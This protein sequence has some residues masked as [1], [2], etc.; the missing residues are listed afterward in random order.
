M[1]RISV[2]ESRSRLRLV[3]EGKLAAPWTVELRRRW[4]SARAQVRGRALVID[5][6]NVTHI[7]REG[8]NVLLDLM[9]EGARFTCKGVFTRR[10]LGQLARQ[11]RCKS[12]PAVM[13][14]SNA[15][16][17]ENSRGQS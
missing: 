14:L 3:I 4:N 7:S 12:E 8:E 9:T 6:R 11:S 13:A 10:V 2:V 15:S 5:L 17:D 16:D 1:M